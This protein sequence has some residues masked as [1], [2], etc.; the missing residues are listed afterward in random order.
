MAYRM[1]EV[2]ILPDSNSKKLYGIDP[3]IITKDD[4]A[5]IT[6]WYK[7]AVSGDKFLGAREFKSRDLFIKYWMVSMGFVEYPFMIF[8]GREGG[9]KSMGMA[10]TA[11]RLIKYFGRK[12]TL[13]FTPPEGEYYR[14]FNPVV[15][16]KEA[17]EY[18]HGIGDPKGLIPRYESDIVEIQKTPAFFN[19]YDED[20]VERIQKELDRLQRIEKELALTGEQVPQ[21]E[22]EKLIIYNAV[23]ALDEG[24]SY[25]DV[26]SQ[27]NLIKLIGRIAR[28][29]RHTHTT[30]LMSYV[31]LADVPQRIILNRATHQVFCKKDW[32]ILGQ[33]SYQF[34]DVRQ[35]N[36]GDQKFMHLKPQDCTHLWNSHNLVSISHD[37]DIHFG[38]KGAKKKKVSVE[39]K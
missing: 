38:N 31:D 30:I 28:R 7:L 23:F 10:V 11:H 6:G 29:R 5:S 34:K 18:L 15:E 26:Q 27:T 32:F 20:F 33:C 39:E 8:Y 22:F 25:G 14:P 36:N 19:F 24:D 9:G 16:R 21:E 4:M 35:G 37:V 13:D 3:V 17:I 12:P 2:V 1:P